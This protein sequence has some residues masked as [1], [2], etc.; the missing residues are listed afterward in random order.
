MK[1]SA[2]RGAALLLV[3]VL[4]AVYGVMVAG[5]LGLMR[6]GMRDAHARLR[7]LQATYTAEAGA[8]DM[9]RKLVEDPLRATGIDSK[10]LDGWTY[11]VRVD[12]LVTSCTITATGRVASPELREEPAA[13]GYDMDR[14]VVVALARNDSSGV[15]NY[16]IMADGDVTLGD[17]MGREP[18]VVGDVY[19]GGNAALHNSSVTGNLDAQGNATGTGRVSGTIRALNHP[20]LP[21]A[22]AVPL[23][24]TDTFIQEARAGGTHAGD[25][26]VNANMSLGPR[27][28][29]GD[30]TV[31]K[32]RRLTLTGSVCVAGTVVIEGDMVG[33]EALVA[34]TV[35][36]RD[37]GGVG[38]TE[39]G[40]LIV[41][42]DT[43]RLLSA[44]GNSRIAYAVFYNRLGLTTLTN[45]EFTGQIYS[46]TVYALDPK[47]F[48]ASKKSRRVAPTPPGGASAGGHSWL[49]MDWNTR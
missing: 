8:E 39:T 4:L 20:P 27:F 6:G 42:S 29:A 38:E 11:H 16:F 24:E 18:V 40:P 30:L 1:R 35:L 49:V 17:G 7:A 44:E 13:A 37:V 5:M 10:T 32:T 33:A 25:L 23:A 41:I 12:N 2:R 14:Q 47:L 28:I 3:L 48:Y 45:K 26:V 22:Q 43:G 21:P 31:E 9:L 19:A 34:D 46:R 15:R 36:V